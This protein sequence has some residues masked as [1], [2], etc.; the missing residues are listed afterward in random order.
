MA[1]KLGLINEDGGEDYEGTFKGNNN[2][3]QSNN[4]NKMGQN[5]YKIQQPEIRRYDSFL[6]S[7][8]LELH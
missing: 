4:E 1:P 3:F 8:N 6:D 5:A 7:T 2:R